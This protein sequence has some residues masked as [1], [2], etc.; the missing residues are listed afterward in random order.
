MTD[1]NPLRPGAIVVRDAASVVPPSP[2]ATGR[3]ERLMIVASGM[4]ALTARLLLPASALAVAAA[5]HDSMSSGSARAEGLLT[6]RKRRVLLSVIGALGW[7][8]HG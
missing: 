3:R 8:R 4:R 1:A 6:E 7:W 2:R 5:V